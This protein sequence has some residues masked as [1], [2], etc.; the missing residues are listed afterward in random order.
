MW[1]TVLPAQPA[2]MRVPAWSHVQV[3]IT[4]VVTDGLDKRQRQASQVGR[5]PEA[6]A[7]ARMAALVMVRAVCTTLAIAS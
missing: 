3:M 5:W 4:Q 1:R 6:G 2:C 7:G